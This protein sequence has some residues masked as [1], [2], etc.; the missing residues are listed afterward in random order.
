MLK[1][2]FLLCLLFSSFSTYASHLA[3]GEISY[4][5]LGNGNYK[6]RVVVFRDCSGI[7]FQQAAVTLSGPV[8]VSCTLI[9]SF[10]ITSNL[11]CV[12]IQC[13][14]PTT[15]ASGKGG[16]SKFVY[17][18]IAN[19]NNLGVA[20]AGGYTWMTSNLPCCRN[21]SSN[22]NCTGEMVLRVKMYSFT[23]QIGTALTPAQVC[24]NSPTFLE[25]P[26]FVV[27]A[28][29]FDTAVFNGFGEDIDL[30]DVLKYNIDFPWIGVGVACNFDPGYSVTTPMPGVIGAGI[31]SLTGA[32]RFNP[33]T[34]GAY[35]MAFRVGSYRYGQLISEVFRDFQASVITG[36]ASAPLPYNPAYTPGSLQYQQQQQIPKISG[37]ILHPVTGLPDRVIVLYAGDT[38]RVNYTVKD[39]FPVLPIPNRVYSYVRSDVMGALGTNQLSGCAEPPCAIIQNVATAAPVTQVNLRSRQQGFGLV[40]DSAGWDINGRIYWTPKAI[41]AQLAGVPA[42]RKYYFGVFAFDDVCPLSGSSSE[43]FEV[44][45]LPAATYLPAPTALC[46][47]GGN[48]QSVQLRWS[49]IIDSLT[50]EV[51][52]SLVAGLS[53]AER[54]QRSIQRRRASFVRADLYRINVIDSSFNLRASFTSPDTS[55]FLDLQV[56]ADSLY[57]YT[58][59]VVSALDSQWLALSL[60]VLA[61]QP[62]L[63]AS[64][65]NMTYQLN[66]PAPFTAAGSP[67]N[68][69]GWYYLFS[70]N[71]SLQSAWTLVDSVRNL[72]Q[73]V[74]PFQL[75]NDTLEFR[76]GWKSGTACAFSYS[77]PIQ[78]VFPLN[79]GV[80]ESVIA[81]QLYPNPVKNQL[82]VRFDGVKEPLGW[83]IYDMAGRLK[84]E[85]QWQN[86]P[87]D[88]SYLPTANYMLFLDFGKNRSS[89]AIFSKED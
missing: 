16:V 68:F 80:N 34:A 73:M 50:L 11:G 3:G 86:G 59:R 82:N 7:P 35:N 15:N 83:K 81:M 61:I 23:N 76:I 2:L 42:V 12:S 22:S 20:P 63:T 31:D 45:V 43:F 70:R 58:L 84:L 77:F 10:D 72:Q 4:K 33:T 25:D 30:G 32:L 53:R 29:P 79:M 13:T 24:D 64:L 57:A 39:S 52:D 38:M 41:H 6:F 26:N 9:G 8:P 69:D 55:S 44:N 14:P 74:R 19:L 78:A 36:P 48:N 67:A 56:P 5:C 37:N 40:A 46:L 27:V 54:L 62:L 51:G 65:P 18:G 17:E 1:R 87:I 75:S 49:G 47:E 66:W 88:V 85:G 89:R 71:I 60:P 28:S 21:A